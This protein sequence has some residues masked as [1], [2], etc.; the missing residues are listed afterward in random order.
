MLSTAARIDDYE[1]AHPDAIY[2]VG[3]NWN[4]GACWSEPGLVCETLAR[5]NSKS[6]GRSIRTT[7]A[8][9]EA[10]DDEIEAQLS[11]EL[12]KPYFGLDRIKKLINI[13]DSRDMTTTSYRRKYVEL[14]IRRSA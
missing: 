10:T 8:V 9:R 12:S 13:A 11:R 14:R 5:T 1:Q 2:L 3:N 6:H 4:P 7:H